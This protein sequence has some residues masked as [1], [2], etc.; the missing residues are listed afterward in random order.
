MCSQYLRPAR[1][2][3][4]RRGQILLQ[5]HHHARHRNHLS[6]FGVG[7]F[8]WV[9]FTLAVY[10]LTFFYRNI[11]LLPLIT[12]PGSFLFDRIHQQTYFIYVAIPGFPK[13]MLCYVT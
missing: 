3:D 10:A 1:G 4:S 5:R 2:G 8:C 13:L 9:I 6:I 12:I 7:L 11:S